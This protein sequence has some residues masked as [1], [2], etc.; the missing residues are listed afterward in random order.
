[1]KTQSPTQFTM[2][3]NDNDPLPLGW[4]VKIDPQTGWPFF[5]DHNNRT[6]TWNDPRH[7]TRKVREPSANGPSTSPEPSPQE[8][9]KTFV[10]EMKH[11]ILRPGYIPIPVFHEGAEVRQQQHPCYSYIQPGTPSQGTRTD[12]RAPSPT[13]GLHG[14]PRSPL[15]GPS[16]SCTSESTAK[17]SS[18]VSYTPE[19]NIQVLLIVVFGL[20]LT[21]FF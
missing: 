13:P 12:G 7:D 16:D 6:T 9:P 15:H 3:S 19:V 18:P 4:E 10:R 11:P 2:A 1:M 21:N 17:S 20:C 14:R 8:P 5:V